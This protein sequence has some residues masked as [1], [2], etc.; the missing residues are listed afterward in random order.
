MGIICGLG[1]A[2]LAPVVAIAVFAG[3]I[4]IPYSVSF[5]SGALLCSICLSRG[6]G[7]SLVAAGKANHITAAI[8]ASAITGTA[9]IILLT[10][11][12]GAPGAVIGELAAELTGVAI[13]IPLVYRYFKRFRRQI[14]E[15]HDPS[16]S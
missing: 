13:Q 7:L 8:A 11:S 10:A 16:S 4:E 9:S 14:D 15:K 3:T 12:L 2:V 1:F 5:L 6:L